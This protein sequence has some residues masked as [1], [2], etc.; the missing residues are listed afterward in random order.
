[1]AV[2][3]IREESMDPSCRG[4]DDHMLSYYQLQHNNTQYYICCRL[5]L[6][7]QGEVPISYMNSSSGNPQFLK[8]CIKALK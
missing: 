4:A 7:N 3:V 6:T 5:L 2:D 8:S 1:M